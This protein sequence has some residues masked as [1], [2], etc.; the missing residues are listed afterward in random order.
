M[1]DIKKEIPKNGDCIV[2][3]DRNNTYKVYYDV[4]FGIFFFQE[5]IGDREE[6]GWIDNGYH[7]ELVTH[8]KYE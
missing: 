8:W 1:I 4:E 2:K 7:P 3:T 6:I 5:P